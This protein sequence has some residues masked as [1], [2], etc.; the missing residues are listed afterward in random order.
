MVTFGLGDKSDTM[1]CASE[2]VLVKALKEYSKR[3]CWF[4]LY[5]KI[6]TLLVMTF[7]CSRPAW[8]M[9]Q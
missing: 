6:V 5:K 3:C 9:G 4:V 2:E 7:E 1:F 8:G